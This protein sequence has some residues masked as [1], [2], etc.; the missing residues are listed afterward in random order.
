[1]GKPGASERTLSYTQ[2]TLVPLSPGPLTPK[3]PADARAVANTLL[4][5]ALRD[6]RT[7]THLQLQKLVYIA[8]G[9]HLGLEGE[10]LFS[11]PVLAWQHGPVIREVYDEFKGSGRQPIAHFYKKLDRSTF[12]E[13]I[14]FVE[15]ASANRMIERVWESYSDVGAIAL[16]GLTHLKGTPWDDVYKDGSGAGRVIPT[17][18]IQEYYRCLAEERGAAQPA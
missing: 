5:L 3:P 8:H 16:R 2:R 14:P 18:S 10:P 11:Q 7:L 1:M 13:K 6:N 15:S 17:E 4:K 9:W 12:L